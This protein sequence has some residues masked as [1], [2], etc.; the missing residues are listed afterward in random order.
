MINKKH[1]LLIIVSTIFLL[2]GCTYGSYSTLKSVENNTSSMMSMRYERFNGYNATPIKVKEGN[3][4]DVSVDI[5][6]NKGKLDMSITDEKGQS[7]YEG[8][9]IPTS[10]FSVRLDKDGDYKLK[11]SGEKHSGSYKITWGKAS[12]DNEK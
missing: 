12:E 2:S 8:K 4:I 11:V 6:S 5:V 7:V 10:S 9:D 1:I 3:P